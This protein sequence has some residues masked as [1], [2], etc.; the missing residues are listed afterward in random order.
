MTDKRTNRGTNR[1]T[2]RLLT[3]IIIHS[4][5]RVILTFNISNTDKICIFKTLLALEI[6][7]CIQLGEHKLAGPRLVVDTI[8]TNLTQNQTKVGLDW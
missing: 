6:M 7:R 2:E 5:P 1:G 4:V 3:D 8:T